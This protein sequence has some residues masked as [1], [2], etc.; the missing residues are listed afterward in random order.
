MQRA[1]L[2]ATTAAPTVFKPVLMGTEMY[3]DGGLVASN[4]SAVAIHEARTLFPDIPIEMVVSVGTGEFVSER[5]SPTFGWDG[6][7]TQIVKSATDTSKIH[8]ILQDV[9]GQGTTANPNSHTSGT[10]YYRVSYQ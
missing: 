8:H 5:V 7:I 2:R 4:P 10:K 9:L 1:A 3:S 6:I